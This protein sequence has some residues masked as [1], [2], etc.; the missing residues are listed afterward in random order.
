MAVS[1]ANISSDIEV[2]KTVVTKLDTSIE[3]ISQVSQDIGKILAVHE[4]RLDA[5]EKVSERRE[6]EIKDLHSRITTSHRE[7]CDKL[8][9]MEA[10]IENKMRENGINATKQHQDIQ[11]EIQTDVEKVAGSVEKISDRVTILEQ[12]RWYIIGG[13]AVIGFLIAKA[14]G[15]FPGLQ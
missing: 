9:N 4:E 5:I 8:D 14:P 6:D 12:W 2:L 13:S 3:K 10:R 7:L 15:L 11:K 1:H